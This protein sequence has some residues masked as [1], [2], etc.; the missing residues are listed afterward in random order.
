MKQGK[1]F[2][3]GSFA[4]KLRKDTTFLVNPLAMAAGVGILMVPGAAFAGGLGTAL[5]DVANQFSNAPK[6]VETLGYFGGAV[7]GVL[8]FMNL[9]KQQD[10]EAHKKAIK[11]LIAGAG[12]FGLGHWMGNIAQTAGAHGSHAKQLLG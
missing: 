2:R 7:F 11:E 6:D 12:L 3:W 8:G 1:F 10:P 4:G 9:R 5:N